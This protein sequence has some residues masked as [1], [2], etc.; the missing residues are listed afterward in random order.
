MFVN[1]YFQ[2]CAVCCYYVAKS[3]FKVNHGIPSITLFKVLNVE[4]KMIS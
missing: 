4:L 1:T 2:D 3:T